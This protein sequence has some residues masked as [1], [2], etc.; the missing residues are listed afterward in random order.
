MPRAL[1]LPGGLYRTV[2]GTLGLPSV[3]SA[4]AQQGWGRAVLLDLRLAV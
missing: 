2:S 4:R 3:W 1:P